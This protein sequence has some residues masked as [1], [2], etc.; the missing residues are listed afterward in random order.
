MSLTHRGGEGV[1]M[2]LRRRGEGVLM[3][4]RHRGGGGIN[5]P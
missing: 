4:L 1:L 2:S 5:E 3:S